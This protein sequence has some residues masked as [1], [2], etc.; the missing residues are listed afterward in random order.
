MAGC[1]F[2]GGASPT[3]T[4]TGTPRPFTVVVTQSITTTDPAAA[5]RDTDTTLVLAV[6]KRLMSVRPGK[7]ELKPAL[8]TDCLFKTPTLMECTI[9]KDLKFSNGDPLTSASVKFSIERAY[10]LAIPHTSVSLLSA[11][12]TITVPDATTVRFNLKYPDSQFGYALA[13]PAA[14]IVDELAYDPDKVR[15]LDKPP[16][17]SGI[18]ALA[19]ADAAHAELVRSQT[20]P[21]G[22]DDPAMIAAATI[23]VVADSAAAEAAIGAGS[24]DVVWRSL[25]APAIA[26]LT[27]EMA[28]NSGHQTKAGFS[29]QSLTGTHRMLLRWNSASPNVL[30]ATLRDAIAAA[31]QPDR[32]L[33]SLV[34]PGLSGQVAAYPIGGTPTIVR[35]G[36]ARVKLTLGY[37]SRLPGVADLSRTVR[38]RLET[39]VGVSVQLKADD[40]TADLWITDDQPWL[41]TPLGWMQVYLE[42]A[43]PGVGDK[44]NQLVQRYGSTID[45]T[46]QAVALTELQKQAAA[47]NTVLPMSLGDGTMFTGKG[48]TVASYGAG[49]QLDLGGLRHA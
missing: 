24:A 19:A 27:T 43:L 34:P 36:G 35:P 45:P 40:E 25:D 44:V 48:T 49:W 26:R 3:P 21:A 16:V 11:L 17:G 33:D 4:P 22:S 8:A 23:L 2:G 32:T 6:Y 7:N 13:T 31:L 14:S 39:Q 1:T 38:E 47:D 41:A 29:R 30:N 20:A 15:P 28:A 10:R 42:A 12:D 37:D 46:V 18:Y 9:P 5:T